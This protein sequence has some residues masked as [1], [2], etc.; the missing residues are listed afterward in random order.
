[1]RNPVFKNE[2]QIENRVHFGEITCHFT[3]N[4]AFIFAMYHRGTTLDVEDRCFYNPLYMAETIEVLDCE[5]EEDFKG[6]GFKAMSWED[7]KGLVRKYSLGEDIEQEIY[8]LSNR[9]EDLR[10][11]L[12][13]VGYLAFMNAVQEKA[14]R[15]I[16][17]QELIKDPGFLAEVRARDLHK[18]LSMNED[19]KA[20]LTKMKV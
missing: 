18:S 7:L 6:S 15:E 17:R 13:S 5:D 8:D 4:P 9:N 12:L 14:I 2:M 19:R 20:D 1:M 16:V 10:D 3:N 11:Y